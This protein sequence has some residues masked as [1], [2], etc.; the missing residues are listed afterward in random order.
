MKNEI[1]EK[2]SCSLSISE[3]I[4]VIEN[5]IGRHQVENSLSMSLL[6]IVLS[7]FT[8][9]VV[10]TISLLQENEFHTS[11]FIQKII[12]SCILVFLLLVCIHVYIQYSSKKLD[13]I[14][15]KLIKFKDK[16]INEEFSTLDEIRN[17]YFRIVKYRCLV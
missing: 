8:L 16:I 11:I 9:I 2:S 4:T 6:S 5:E 14:R 7:S 15:G 1:S 13:K 12:M 10:L 17:E 3:W